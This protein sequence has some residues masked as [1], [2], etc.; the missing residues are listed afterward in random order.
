MD[1]YDA[2]DRLEDEALQRL[3]DADAMSDEETDNETHTQSSQC[4][5]KP[6]TVQLTQQMER[7]E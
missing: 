6:G 7:E 1:E 4:I 3:R 2:Y 5:I